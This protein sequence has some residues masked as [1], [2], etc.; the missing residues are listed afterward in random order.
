MCLPEGPARLAE[1]RKLTALYQEGGPG[2]FEAFRAL[3]SLLLALTVLDTQRGVVRLT[4]L[5]GMGDR[6][7]LG[8]WDGPQDP[9]PLN[10]GRW[11]RVSVGLYL[12]PTPGGT[13]LKVSDASYQYQMDREPEPDRWI[14]RYDYLRTP[15]SPHPASHFQ[16]NAT[17]AEE[18]LP[19]AVPLERIHFPTYRISLEAVIRCLA[20][21]IRVPCNE[22]PEI[23]RPV[24][25]E[26]ER[27]FLS[28][29]HQ[30]L[31]G[32]ER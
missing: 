5:P 16:V 15:P 1:A 14:F 6:A 3:A 7:A 18:R 17:M 12:E 24:L 8:G 2:A 31:S 13:R 29:A 22:P 21:Q 27:T 19:A 26:T 20:E 11:L 23:W 4:R 28:I 32:P 9:V 10:D 25:A 30:P